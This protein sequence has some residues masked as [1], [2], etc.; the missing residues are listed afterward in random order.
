MADRV[1]KEY[2]LSFQDTDTI[3]VEHALGKRGLG[4]QLLVDGHCRP[5][6]IS[7]VIPDIDDPVNKFE[8]QLTSPQTGSIQVF[9]G[10]LVPVTVLSEEIKALLEASGI[11][12]TNPP[13]SQ[14]DVDDKP[15]AVI[16]AFGDRSAYAADLFLMHEGVRSNLSGGV[17]DID[18][19]IYSITA[20]TR[21]AANCK[22]HIYKNK[23]KTPIITVELVNERKKVF[24]AA[25]EVQEGDELA[26][27]MQGKAEFPT[28]RIFCRTGGD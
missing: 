3:V 11:S 4:F 2:E 21:R 12:P 5:D 22:F 16:F 24:A 26:V 10:S 19:Q 27:A 23:I 1:D 7:S 28:V 15:E 8:V 25:V 17:L 6:L 18:R 20:A 9:T 14:Q 13:A